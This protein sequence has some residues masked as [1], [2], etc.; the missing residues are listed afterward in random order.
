MKKINDLPWK[1]EAGVPRAGMFRV[2][3]DM[4]EAQ[5]RRFVDQILALQK[6]LDSPSPTK[7]QMLLRPVFR[8]RELRKAAAKKAPRRRAK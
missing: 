4:T 6:I 8:S 2:S 1:C 7:L 5:A 3:C